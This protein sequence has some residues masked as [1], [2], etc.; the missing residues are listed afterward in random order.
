MSHPESEVHSSLPLALVLMTDFQTLTLLS[1][2][3]NNGVQRR[4][5]P[6]PICLIVIWE[7]LTHVKPRY[8][9]SDLCSPSSLW[10]TK[11]HRNQPFLLSLQFFLLW[12]LILPDYNTSFLSLFNQV[13]GPKGHQTWA[14]APTWPFTSWLSYFTL[15]QLFPK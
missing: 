8:A 9:S 10:Q 14:Q 7:I 11:K 3:S 6:Q 1:G 2:Y 15:L 4:H 12:S 13:W 5:V